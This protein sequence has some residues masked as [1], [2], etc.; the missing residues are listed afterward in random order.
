MP[1]TASSSATAAKLPSKAVF[2]RRE[3]VVFASRCSIV[4]TL[5]SGWFGSTSATT[6]PHGRD[7][8]GRLAGDANDE[9]QRVSHVFQHRV[10][11]LQHHVS[12]QSALPHIADDPHHRLPVRPGARPHEVDSFADR[13][14]AGEV[15]FL[16][17]LVDDHRSRGGARV[18]RSERPSVLHRNTHR[19]EVI[20]SDRRPRNR[21]HLLAPLQLAQ[22][23]RW[24][25][26]DLRQA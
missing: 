9:A 12:R 16:K 11:H 21:P 3:V 19:V 7:E 24:P 8:M 25:A 2:S 23:D 26:L 1:T 15:M 14:F 5:W 22:V 13:A 20:E 10:I 18:L 6:R 17:R 4:I